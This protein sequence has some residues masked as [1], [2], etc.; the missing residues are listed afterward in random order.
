ML[1]LNWNII[2]TFVNLIVLFLLLKKFLFK[3]VSE[4]MEKRRKQI[5]D[6]LRY[7]EDRKTEAEELKN[8]YE[9]ALI[10][11]K[12]DAV[13][14]INSAK[15]KAGSEYDLILKSA[16]IDAEKLIKDARQTIEI[17][18]AKSVAEIKSQIAGLALMAAEKVAGK[19]VDSETNN[20]I[21]DDFIAEAGGL[22]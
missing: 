18:K 12:N 3:P 21:V 9:R 10:N 15:E 19:N 16:D 2:W 4:I 1:A 11:A 7:A 6:S 5:E 8:Q 20:K 22:K 14:I 17:E 13:E